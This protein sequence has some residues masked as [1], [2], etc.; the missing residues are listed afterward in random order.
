MRRTRQRLALL[1]GALLLTLAPSAWGNPIGTQYTV[2]TA[3]FVSIAGPVSVTFDG[4][5]EDVAGTGLT[6]NEMATPLP[7]GNELIEFWIETTSGDPF[8]TGTNTSQSSALFIEDVS[9]VQGGLAAILVGSSFVYFTWDGTPLP[10]IDV[11]G[12]GLVFLPHPLDPTIQVLQ[13]FLDL[14]P[15]H[16]HLDTSDV[17]ATLPQVYFA[18]GLQ[19]FTNLIDDVHIGYQVVHIPEPSAALLWLCGVAAIGLMGRAR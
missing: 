6:L 3:N 10:M 18:L 16:F 19:A 12:S 8:T 4:V 13:Y 2:Q 9:W 15:R 11:L 7:N 17:S 5:A 1:G 14:P